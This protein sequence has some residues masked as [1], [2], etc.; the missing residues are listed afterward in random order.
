M[1]KSTFKQWQVH[2]RGDGAFYCEPRLLHW[3]QADSQ[4][5]K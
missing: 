3:M 5:G 4:T 1:I 2:F